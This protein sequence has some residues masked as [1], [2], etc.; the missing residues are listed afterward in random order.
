MPDN[1][2]AFVGK[3]GCQNKEICIQRMADKNAM[4]VTVTSFDF[5]KQQGYVVYDHVD[6]LDWAALAEGHDTIV[7]DDCWA[8]EN[9][10]KLL[11]TGKRIFLL[12]QLPLIVKRIVSDMR[13]SEDA[14][15]KLHVDADGNLDAE[16]G[17]DAAGV[18]ASRDSDVDVQDSG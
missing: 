13:K 8:D 15:T 1:F 2:T 4:V 3:R 11:R 5:W 17:A 10:L 16:L 6:N 12:Y 9:I 18:H 7:V 14:I